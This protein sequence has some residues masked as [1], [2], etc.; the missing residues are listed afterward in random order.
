[1][2]KP[3]MIYQFWPT[4]SQHGN[5]VFGALTRLVIFSA[6]AAAIGQADDDVR[7][8]GRSVLGSHRR[9]G[10]GTRAFGAAR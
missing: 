10:A 2:R 8:R 5:L 4:H 1:M 7:Q 3:T 6:L 9:R